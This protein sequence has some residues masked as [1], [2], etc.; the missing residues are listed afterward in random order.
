MEGEFSTN[1]YRYRSFDGG[2]S[3]GRV[4]RYTDGAR[5]GAFSVRDGAARLVEAWDQSDSS[6]PRKWLRFHRELEEHS[7]E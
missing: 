1:M 3:W 4:R 7:L 5:M 6:K 2:R